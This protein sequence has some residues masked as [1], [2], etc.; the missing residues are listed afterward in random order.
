MLSVEDWA[1]RHS[2]SIRQEFENTLFYFVDGT[3]VEVGDSGDVAFRLMLW[4]NKHQKKAFSFFVLVA[5]D[6]RIV[7]V[8]SV[9][10][11]STHDK[12]AWETSGAVDKLEQF[13]SVPNPTFSFA[14]GGDKAYPN[15]TVPAGWT[16]YITKSGERE[17][18]PKCP[19]LK[20]TPEIAKH[21]AVVERTIGKLKD[22][23]VL[24]QKYYLGMDMDR[25][26]KIVFILANLVNQ[27]FF[28]A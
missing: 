10:Y 1:S 14:I 11:G 2:E 24:S 21:R 26:E 25:V 18:A 5:P 9:D 17:G 19:E 8:S 22:W 23:Q 15:M 7:F 4:N 27:E 28:G 12:T 3:V 6:G 13:Y 16:K 20:F